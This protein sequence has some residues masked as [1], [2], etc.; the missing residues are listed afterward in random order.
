MEITVGNVE[1]T[2]KR[3]IHPVIP[4][5][6]GSRPFASDKGVV[7]PGQVLGKDGAGECIPA[8]ITEDEDMTGTV[9]GAN[10]DFTYDAGKKLCP[11]SV[12]ITHGEQEVVDDGF[13]AL[14]GDGSGTV[15]YGTGEVSVT[16]DTAP[17]E[18]SGAPKID[19]ADEPERV[20]LETVNTVAGAD[21]N[22]LVLEQG[23]IIGKEVKMGTV[24]VPAYI[25]ERLRLKGIYFVQ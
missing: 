3:I 16:L 19:F 11:G 8:A 4:H 6:A 15:S 21:G 18:A 22:G 9:D 5:I 17:A 2:D 10:K 13:G 12:T 7:S 14:T 24:D 25:K 20:A 23:A 1:I